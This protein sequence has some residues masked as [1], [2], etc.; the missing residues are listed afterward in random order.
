MKGITVSPH[1]DAASQGVP[2]VEAMG[3][4]MWIDVLKASLEHGLA[5]RSWTDYLYLTIGGTL[6]NAGVSG[7]SFRHGPEVSNVLHLQ[8][9]TGRGEVVECSPTENSELF[10]AVLGGLG[11]FGI[12][13]KARIV[14]EK[15]PQRVR[16]MRALY[17]DFATFKT[18]QE[19][20]ISANKPFDYVEGF[21]VKNDANTVNGWG[22]VPFERTDINEAM[23]PAEA[24]SIMYCLEVTKAYS[25]ADDV[26]AVVERMLAP[27]SFRQELLFKT[28]TTYFHFLD[29]V[30][31]AEA[32]KN[33]PTPSCECVSIPH[34][35]EWNAPWPLLS[36]FIPAYAIEQ[37]D[38]LVLKR[39][40]TSEFNGPI[41]VYPMNKSK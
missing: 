32:A 30:Y 7:Q 10:F 19:L 24:E 3:G 16:W 33:L 34:A 36:L 29:R 14:L 2:F 38:L 20:L 28:D 15:A 8:V 21:V 6:S 40:V 9:V 31:A 12:I 41:L 26:D 18:D 4:E 13:T 17:T 39:L 11:Q 35:C 1:G 27:L 22:A 37:F 5:P 25:G 23:I